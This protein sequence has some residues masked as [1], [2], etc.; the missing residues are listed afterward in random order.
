MERISFKHGPKIR[1]ADLRSAK[2]TGVA[3]YTLAGNMGKKILITISSI[4][5]GGGA[6]KV[7]AEVARNFLNRWFATELLTFYERENLHVFSWSVRCLKETV[8]TNPLWNFFKLF[9]R[10]KKISENVEEL[11]IDIS[12]SFMEE[13]NFPNIVAKLLFR[14]SAKTV[15]S[16]RQSQCAIGPIYRL[17]WKI[18][19]PFAD[20]IVT[21][22][23]EEKR[24]LTKNFRVPEN[25]I[26]VI[27]NGVN[28]EEIHS[29]SKKPLESTD[30]AF[31]TS[32]VFTFVSVGRLTYQ[33]N[34]PLLI[35]SFASVSKKNPNARLLIIGGGKLQSELEALA[36]KSAPGKIFFTGRRENIY[37]LLARADC[38]ILTSLWEGFPNVLIEAMAC[39]LPIISTDCKTGPKEILRKNADMI[40]DADSL[41]LAEYGMLVPQ[42]NGKLI[43]EAIAI[44]ITDAETRKNYQKKS[45]ERVKSFSVE[46]VMI[47]W[48]GL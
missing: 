31:F 30:S 42:S 1:R 15:I 9:R 44:M 38:F 10:A 16:I 4:E 26:T 45:T 20:E 3:S 12:I 19:Y 36:E 48:L 17:L 39:G 22:T 11:G 23:E 8:T 46:S 41:E 37:P 32:D 25:R 34:Y 7:A 47:K 28:V 29:L 2:D 24:N 43:S 6:E 18:L 35:E 21:V 33:K 27:P 40:K 13:A 14:S 5:K